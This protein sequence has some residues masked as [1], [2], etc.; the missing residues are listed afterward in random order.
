LT[1][2]HSIIE[3]TS[4]GESATSSSFLLRSDG[5]GREVPLSE[6]L[7]LRAPYLFFVSVRDF[8]VCCR[9][10]PSTLKRA[11]AATI[12]CKFCIGVLQGDTPLRCLLL[13]VAVKSK[14]REHE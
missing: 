14:K 13:R 2:S 11:E 7:L 6:H 9:L 12:S 10:E 4:L 8:C 3:F 1:Q 5:R